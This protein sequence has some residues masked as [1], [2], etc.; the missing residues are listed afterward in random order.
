MTPTAQLQLTDP[1]TGSRSWLAFSERGEILETV[2]V[3]ALGVPD[4]DQATVADARGAGGA[5]A[6]EALHAALSA[7]EAN[8]RLV[9]LEVRRVPDEAG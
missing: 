7:A 5:P 3:D 1:A 4:W 2:D 6:Y 8:A 9:G